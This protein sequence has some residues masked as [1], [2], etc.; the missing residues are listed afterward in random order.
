MFFYEKMPV[1]NGEIKYMFLKVRV[2]MTTLVCLVLHQTRLYFQWCINS[3][4]DSGQYVDGVQVTR[5]D[6]S[7][8]YNESANGVA[9]DG[10][11]DSIVFS[12]G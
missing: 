8:V 12:L 1:D 10:G 7:D 6:D 5:Y 4:K 2:N 9:L 11:V 3:V